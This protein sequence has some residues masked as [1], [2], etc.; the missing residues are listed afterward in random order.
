MV[1]GRTNN[2]G[3]VGLNCKVQNMSCNLP[4]LKKSTATQSGDPLFSA[5]LLSTP[6]NSPRVAE[7]WGA[8]LIV[9]HSETIPLSS[10]FASYSHVGR[11]RHF[12]RKKR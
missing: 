10:S 12:Y 4:Y 1:D 7:K 5:P 6:P 3:R 11:D 9:Y 2:K 8:W